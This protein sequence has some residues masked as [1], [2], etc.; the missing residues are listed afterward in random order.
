MIW[1]SLHTWP[2]INT[3]LKKLPKLFIINP[4]PRSQKI[5]FVGPIRFIIL[6]PIFIHIVTP[7]L[8]LLFVITNSYFVVIGT[9]KLL[10][11][12]V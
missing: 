11:L 1:S 8:I 2:P 12:T 3:N 4:Y 10:S 9:E 6:F 7:T 5:L